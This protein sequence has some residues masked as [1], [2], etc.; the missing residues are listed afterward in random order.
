MQK[1]RTVYLCQ[2]CQEMFHVHRVPTHKVRDVVND[3]CE[4][5]TTVICHEGDIVTVRRRAMHA[6]SNECVGVGEFVGV[7]VS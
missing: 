1:Y 6:C 2:V 7:R 5:E 4:K 3:L